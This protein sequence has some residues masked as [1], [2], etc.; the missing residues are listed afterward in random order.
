MIT[1]FNSTFKKESAFKNAPLVPLE[2]AEQKQL[3]EWW[4][5]FCQTKGIHEKCL[6]A[7]PNGGY[8]NA[9]ESHR[10]KEEGVR[11]GIPDLMLA[12]PCGAFH[13]LF[14]ELK[15]LKG[16]RVSDNQKEMLVVFH[17]LGYCVKLCKGFAEAQQAITEYLKDWRKCDE[18]NS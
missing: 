16:G 2:S 5:F 8:R 15:R 3:I 14:V 4:H 11:A 13:G 17:R 7:V 9:R 10:L 1:K 18:N 6:F 12:V